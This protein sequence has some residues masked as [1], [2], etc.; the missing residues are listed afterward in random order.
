MTDISPVEVNVQILQKQYRLQ[1]MPED[2][3]SLQ[4]SARTLNDYMKDMRESLVTDVFSNEKLAIAVAVNLIGT[5]ARQQ[6]E[7]DELTQRVDRL[8][9][10]V[11]ENSKEL[12]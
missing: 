7:L 11:L 6:E 12:F 2:V 1:C 3:E 10:R 8:K 9:N 5:I 4:Q